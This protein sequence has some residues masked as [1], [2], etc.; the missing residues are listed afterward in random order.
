MVTI[1][2]H[3]IEMARIQ[4]TFCFGAIILTL[5]MTF[6]IVR[7]NDDE[8]L[9]FNPKS[10][11]ANLLSAIKYRYGIDNI[12]IT[13]LDLCDETGIAKD[14]PLYMQRLASEFISPGTYV[15]VERKRTPM[16]N[17]ANETEEGGAEE[18]NRLMGTIYTTLLNNA[19]KLIPGFT[20]RNAVQK[21][22]NPKDTKKARRAKETP[23]RSL[24]TASPSSMKSPSTLPA[25][26]H[27]KT[28]RS[29]RGM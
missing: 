19:D 1:A 3:V 9:L 5:K 29:R 6:I 28:A 13:N 2:T 24:A 16:E 12:D 26:K 15:V 14:L 10:R 20:P 23:D 22:T 4:K 18:G 11:I 21:S 7:C 8:K 27:T 25:S 17:S